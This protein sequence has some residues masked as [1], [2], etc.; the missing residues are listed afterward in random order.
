LN[1]EEYNILFVAVS[2]IIF[3]ASFVQGFSG[4][5]FALVSIP[6]LTMII[7][8]K[9]AISLGALCGLTINPYLVIKYRNNFHYRDLVKLIIGALIGIPAGVIFL[10]DAD[11]AII[12]IILSSVIII[13]VTFAL[14]AIKKIITLPKQIEYF[15]G[16]ISGLLGGALNTNGPPIMIYMNLTIKDKTQKKSLIIGYFFITSLIIVTSHSV[17]GLINQIV[18]INY[19]KVFIFIILGLLLGELLF[20]KINEKSYD[21]IILIGLFF[22]ALSLWFL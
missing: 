17:T 20:N 2:L 12:K 10:S 5:G 4:F 11:P 6:L 18:F 1:Y 9:S 22:I 15:V 19:L 21:R 16:L 3:L 8:I 7:D 14:F 13:Y